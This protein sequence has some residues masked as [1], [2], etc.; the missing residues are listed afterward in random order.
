MRRAI[1][2]TD[3]SEDYPLDQMGFVL[4]AYGTAQGSWDGDIPTKS[5]WVW[6]GFILKYG[7]WGG[8][9]GHTY[10]HTS[11]DTYVR[12]TVGWSGV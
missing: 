2:T 4:F 10:V 12:V 1:N 6:L 8:P 11:I 9:V 7:E 3:Q 5:I